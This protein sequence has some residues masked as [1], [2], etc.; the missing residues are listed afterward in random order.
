VNDVGVIIVTLGPTAA[1]FV[2]TAAALNRD[3]FSPYEFFI[4]ADTAADACQV[5]LLIQ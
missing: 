2:L 5:T 4:D 3:V 1:P